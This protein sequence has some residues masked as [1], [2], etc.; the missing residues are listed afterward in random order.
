MSSINESMQ[1]FKDLSTHTILHNLFSRGVLNN[2]F[3]FI[4]ELLC[5]I[6]FP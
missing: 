6:N 3:S 2:L 5:D 4:K 1:F